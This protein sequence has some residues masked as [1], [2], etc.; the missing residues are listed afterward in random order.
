MTPLESEEVVVAFSATTHANYSLPVDMG[1]L[2]EGK[3]P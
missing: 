3:G 2:P 1:V